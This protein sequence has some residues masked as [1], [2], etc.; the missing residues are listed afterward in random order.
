MVGLFK[1]ATQS[2][3]NEKVHIEQVRRAGHNWSSGVITDAV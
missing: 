2:S 1:A 3:K